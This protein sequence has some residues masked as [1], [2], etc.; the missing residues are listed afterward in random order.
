MSE[1]QSTEGNEAARKAAL[2]K[3]YGAATSRLREEHQAAF[4]LLYT[5]EAKKLGVEWHPRPTTEEKAK[6]ELAALL[7]ANPELFD[8]LDELRPTEGSGK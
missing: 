2:R 3:A 1:A 4:N 5:E 8:Y 7:E 6:Q